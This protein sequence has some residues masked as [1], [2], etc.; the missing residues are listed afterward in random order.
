MRVK[1]ESFRH[2][3]IRQPL[4]NNLA[5]RLQ[6]IY[7]LVAIDIVC[8]QVGQLEPANV[9]P[10]TVETR[11]ALG[12][13]LPVLLRRLDG[14]VRQDRRLQAE[15]H[16]PVHLDV[17]GLVDDLVLSTRVGGL[18]RATI[19]MC[20]SCTHCWCTPHMLHVHYTRALLAHCKSI[21]RA[22]DI[23]SVLPPAT[24]PPAPARRPGLR[25]GRCA[26]GPPRPSTWNR[27][28]D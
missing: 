2:P 7:V 27:P 6:E 5:L 16:A 9:K 28:W 21:T 20:D 22:V 14:L 17:L 25:A 10:G 4:G 3:A 19:Q 1:G 23:L 8:P 11:L 12:V 18:P 15:H 26:A 24:D 13:A